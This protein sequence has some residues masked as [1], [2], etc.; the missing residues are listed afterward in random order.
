LGALIFLNVLLAL[1]T[2]HFFADSAP[3]YFGDPLI[4]IYSIFQL[5][6]LEGWNDIPAAI[7]RGSDSAL[8]TGMT[9]FYFAVVVVIGGIFGIGL[10]NA[11]FV[12][13]MTM[14][15]NQELERKVDELTREIR[16]LRERLAP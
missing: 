4:S 15:N 11:V 10:A 5:F 16:A 14:D 13:E 8:T 6:T 2:C 1:V 12:D 9:R 3:Q 7:T